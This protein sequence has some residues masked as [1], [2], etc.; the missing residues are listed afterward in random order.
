MELK[1]GTSFEVNGVVT[2]ENTAKAV[3]SSDLPVFA[4]PM[5]MAMMESAAAQ[6]AA[7]FLDEGMT[8][9]GISIQSSH[10]AATPVGMKVRAVA[11]ITGLDR[12]RIDFSVE[13]YDECGRIGAGVHSRFI[14][15]AQPFLEKANA[16]L[17]RD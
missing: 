12:R 16:K 11:T 7:Q 2:R 3:G 9:V 1:I 14:V 13:A 4:T 10:D 17:Q 15:Q 5:M 8:T 6:C